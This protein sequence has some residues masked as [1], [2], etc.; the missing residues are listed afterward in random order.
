MTKALFIILISL[1]NQTLKVKINRVNCSGL[2][3]SV[4]L[5]LNE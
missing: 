1:I 2:E 3:F 5:V 4:M